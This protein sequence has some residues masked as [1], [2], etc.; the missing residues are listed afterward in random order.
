[1][2]DPGSAWVLPATLAP[3]E[4]GQWIVYSPVTRR[5]QHIEER[6]RA[7]LYPRVTD[8][9]RCRSVREVGLG[10]ADVLEAIHRGLAVGVADV[11]AVA[12]NRPSVAPQPIQC[13]AILTK[14]R[15][16]VL[17][18]ALSACV[19]FVQRNSIALLVVDQSSGKYE[20]RTRAIVA[21][22]SAAHGMAVTYI[23]SPQVSRLRR[24]IARDATLSDRAL[25]FLLNGQGLSDC[26]YGAAV[27][28]AVLQCA[29]K[30]IAIVDDDVILSRVMVR[31]GKGD[32]LG[33]GPDGDP[34]IIDVREPHLPLNR[35]FKES[36]ADPL[37]LL[38]GELGANLTY[39]FQHYRRV[40]WSAPV[41]QKALDP[42]GEARIV[43]T[44]LGIVG[45]CGMWSLHSY[46]TLPDAALVRMTVSQAR[47]KMLRRSR[48]VARSAP[49][50]TVTGGGFLMTAAVA[51]ANTEP[52]LPFV[53]IC[54]NPDGIFAHCIAAFCR[55]ALH[56][57]RPESVVHSKIAA[58]R[59][60]DP[61]MHN[62]SVVRLSDLLNYLIR[63][64]CSATH[65]Y[66]STA[67]RIESFGMHLEALAAHPGEFHE[68][69][70]ESRRQLLLSQLWYLRQRIETAHWRAPARS[71]W[72]QDI[73]AQIT[74]IGRELLRPS[75]LL[76]EFPD[77]RLKRVSAAV[78]EF[79][80]AVRAWRSI[81]KSARK[82]EH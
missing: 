51:F 45:D 49:V 64:H 21:G 34:T 35:A 50:T 27:N 22:V 23:G 75:R 7:L 18:R 58:P 19:P 78:A 57:F 10:Q 20:S 54:R 53:P 12:L 6:L 24:L 52:L 15:P 4:E 76:F 77:S 1:M 63:C 79:G 5:V 40:E 25:H 37:Q 13:L 2:L 30:A 11:S 69:I 28:V 46:A 48:I 67:A 8:S 47:Y 56:L 42:I 59:S 36:G 9:V 70:A 55:N 62:A 39:L 26:T 82:V 60:C 16:A 81:W 3:A 73:R 38:G 74:A 68:V 61:Q 71:L 72:E 66:G 14:N 80:G 41:V 31:P 44:A 65:C 17:K 43:A 29:G 32:V 33:V